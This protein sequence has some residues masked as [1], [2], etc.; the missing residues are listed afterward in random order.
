MASIEDSRQ[1]RKRRKRWSE[2]I[3]LAVKVAI[4]W[5]RW[6]V[7]PVVALV[8]LYGCLFVLQ[9]IGLVPDLSHGSLIP[10]LSLEL[11]SPEMFDDCDEWTVTGRT[12]PGMDVQVGVNQRIVGTVK[13]DPSGSFRVSI[14]SHITPQ[15][16]QVWAQALH[17]STGEVVASESTQFQHWCKELPTVDMAIHLTDAGRLWVAGRAAPGA[18]IDLETEEGSFVGEAVADELG[19]FDEL[20]PFEGAQSPQLLRVH[21]DAQVEFL[22]PHPITVTQ[23]PLAE[24]PLA[25]IAHV[26][27]TA[28][29]SAM[30]VK[31]ELPDTHPYFI[32]LAQGYLSAD[33]FVSSSF[34]WFSMGWGKVYTHTLSSQSGTGVVELA[35][36]WPW[37]ISEFRFGS[38]V[39]YIDPSPGIGSFPLLTDRDEITLRFDGIRP[40][41]FD[42]PL[43]TD[44]RPSSATWRG[45]I[46]NGGVIRVGLDLPPG[47]LV[48]HSLYPEQPDQPTESEEEKRR[49]EVKMREFLAGIESRVVGSFV[50][51]TWGT[52]ISLI[53]HAGLLWLARRGKFGRQKAWKP[54]VAL[55]LVLA[56]WRSWN[57][58]YFLLLSGPGHW[59]QA[60]V[61]YAR[62][63]LMMGTATELQS[64]FLADV[65]NNAF[66]LLFVLCL[67]LV[68]LY[69]PVIEGRLGWRPTAAPHRRSFLRRLWGGIRMIYVAILLALLL[70]TFQLDTLSRFEWFGRVLDQ[71]VYYLD[72]HMV[73]MV[74]ILAAFR[75]I[76][77][78]VL[79]VLLLLPFSG[80]G[81]LCGVGLLAVA[82]RALANHPYLN[83]PEGLGQIGNQIPWWAV[84]IFSGLAAYPLVL[85]LL[86]R[87][88]PTLPDDKPRWPH[89]RLALTL[90]LV[91]MTLWRLPPTWLLAVSGALMVWA[92]GWLFVNSLRELEPVTS[93]AAWAK[94]W[95][96]VFFAA[97]VGA[98]L[99]ITRPIPQPGTALEF[100]DL[101]DLITELDGIF[102]FILAL[103]LILQMRG[104]ALRRRRDR[105]VLGRSVLEVAI[106]LFGVFLLNSSA[107]WLFI[108]VPFLVGLL[109]ARFWL[110][111]PIARLRPLRSALVEG[112]KHRKRFIQDILDA[113]SAKS[114]F[115][116]I[117]KAMNKKLEAAGL[118]LEEYKTKL[119][120]YEQEF[121]QGL[122]LEEVKPGYQS[123]DIVFAV[124]EMGLWK[125]TQIAI[126]YGAVLATIPLL[127]ALY[128]YL[129]VGQV[130]YP[131]PVA[132]L[133]IFLIQSTASWLLYA[134]FFGYYYVHLRGNSGLTKGLRLFVG[135]VV[136][137]AVLR[138]LNTPS[139]EEMKPFFLWVTQIFLFCTLLGLLSADYRL[140]RQNGFHMRDLLA[141]H[142]LPV[143]SVYASSVVAA[144]TPTIIALI[145]GRLGDVVT[146]FL[147]TVL[148]RV[149]T[150][151]P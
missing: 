94:H 145:S 15:V 149:P 24:I 82:V 6:L 26:E 1:D 32:T 46:T 50:S 144:V 134:F 122:A 39:T 119:G 13:A 112:A 100:D 22:V 97:L 88:T 132:N 91:S 58:F 35:G 105:V 135:L 108:P 37:P 14:D 52:L 129:P 68:P 51:Q 124:G 126:R 19:I 133:I 65:G 104:Y 73:A 66:W 102:V 127:I 67:A 131:Y 53:P 57:Y 44:L 99:I 62:Y 78:I 83:L 45:P 81:A 80:R 140:L 55:V 123:R 110:F 92:I 16:N 9:F 7:R 130:K 3:P 98:G 85:H 109:M 107:R 103:A 93:L 69:L 89:R 71:A 113:A 43:P 60:I 21:T 118:T 47:A 84:L 138:L 11:E 5:A 42:G 139:L 36:Q 64:S 20:I 18:H 143:L 146:F 137:F 30:L 72:R 49:A 86:R 41:W 116:A 147:E 48:G 115:A 63:T 25:R 10:T 61:T 75:I 8:A 38:Y 96:Y 90:V 74:P 95:P 28:D 148:P 29:S 121:E 117:R 40:A 141:V 136:P 76:W 70:L 150:G 27:L 59:L 2:R 56:I 23:A 114:R 128:E 125:N 79:L 31:V 17:P 142:N 12:Q 101:F 77:P 106:F 151:T 33:D 54:I 4:D 111:R 34:G 120:S 87:L